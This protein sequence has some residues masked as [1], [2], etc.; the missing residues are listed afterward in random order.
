MVQSLA[1][2]SATDDRQTKLHVKCNGRN[3]KGGR[4]W[5]VACRCRGLWCYLRWAAPCLGL[6]K[7]SCDTLHPQDTETRPCWLA[8]TWKFLIWINS[9]F[10][11]GEGILA[12]LHDCQHI[13]LADTWTLS[14]SLLWIFIGIRD[15]KCVACA[16]LLQTKIIVT[17]MSQTVPSLTR[18]WL[19]KQDRDWNSHSSR[20][21]L[22][23]PVVCVCVCVWKNKRVC[24]C[25]FAMWL[26]LNS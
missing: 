1:R 25:L 4:T 11:V 24:V 22:S 5:R 20:L 23:V 3:P 18:L 13:Q 21:Q 26:A 15:H 9:C 16:L 6:A 8:R 12:I 14:K 19:N 7:C 17:P 2:V 10:P